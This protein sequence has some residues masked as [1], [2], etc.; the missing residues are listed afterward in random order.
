MVAVG[1]NSLFDLQVA[2]RKQVTLHPSSVLF[3]SRP[4]CVIYN[5]LVQTTKCYMR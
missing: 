1:S 5:E 4:N 3:H 2:S